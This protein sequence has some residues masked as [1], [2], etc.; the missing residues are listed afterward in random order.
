MKLTYA[1][2]AFLVWA[3]AVLAPQALAETVFLEA[4]TMQLPVAGWRVSRSAQARRASRAAVLNGAKDDVEA[5]AWVKSAVGTSGR[6]RIWVRYMQHSRW[7]GPFKLTVSSP[8][9]DDVGAKVLDLE[10][11]EATPDWEYRWDAFEADL[12]AGPVTLRLSKHEQRNCSGYVR[13]VDCFLLT[14]DLELVPDHIPFGPQT[15]VRVTLG[16]GYER[17]VQIHVFADHYRSPWYGHYHLSKGGVSKGL[18]P[19]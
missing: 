2:L 1:M 16:K 15:Y 8:G 7:R 5:T 19:P 13:N 10:V 9:R 6:W 4:E 14:D 11:D 17:P 18:A 12:D 3:C